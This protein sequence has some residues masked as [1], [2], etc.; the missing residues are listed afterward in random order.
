MAFCRQCGTEMPN[1]ATFCSNCGM[2]VGTIQPLVYVKTKVPGRGFGISSMVLGIIGF[3]YSFLYSITISSML[4]EFENSPLSMNPKSI[5][6]AIIMLAVLPVLSLCF[7]PVAIKRGYKNGVSI[8]GLIMGV[9]ALIG[10]IY[11]A[12]V[13]LNY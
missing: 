2:P 4:E 5:L 1:E 12:F 11:I 8:S 9:L 3:V 6:P 7:S 10:Y 13:I